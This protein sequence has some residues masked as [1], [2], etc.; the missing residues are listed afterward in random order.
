ML[1]VLLHLFIC[2]VS[3]WLIGSNPQTLSVPPPPHPFTPRVRRNFATGAAVLLMSSIWSHSHS[4]VFAAWSALW[5][6]VHR[7]NDRT[8]Q[9]IYQGRGFGIQL[10]PQ[11]LFLR[12]CFFLNMCLFSPRMRYVKKKKVALAGDSCRDWWRLPCVKG[13]IRNMYCAE[14]LLTCV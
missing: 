9:S 4:S 5:V 10:D 12:T 3:L 14:S 11:P 8:P 1:T 2:W 6:T 7:F 13:P